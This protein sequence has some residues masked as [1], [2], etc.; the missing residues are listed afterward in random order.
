M[1]RRSAKAWSSAY[2][3]SLTMCDHIRPRAGQRGRSMKMVIALECQRKLSLQGSG[4]MDVR[5]FIDAEASGFFAALKEWLAIPSISGDPDRA[6]DL[7]RSATW[8][9]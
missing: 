6:G 3:T 2:E 4:S 9:A 7:R 1:P 8:L 5:E